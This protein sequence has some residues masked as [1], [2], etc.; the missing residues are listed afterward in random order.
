MHAMYLR[1]ASRKWTGPAWLGLLVFGLLAKAPLAAQSFIENKGQ[2]SDQF[3]APNHAV[4]YLLETPNN[5]ISLRNGGFSYDTYTV[6]RL[7]QPSEA[8]PYPT[9]KR[10]AAPVAI[11]VHYH[12]VDVTLV[13]CDPSARFRTSIQESRRS[14]GCARS[15]W[16]CTTMSIR[17]SI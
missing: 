7:D 1:I 6:E 16:C 8:S 10:S 5:T 9:T 14:S 15:R 13:G 17:T 12:R 3:G 11:T 2:V 4:R